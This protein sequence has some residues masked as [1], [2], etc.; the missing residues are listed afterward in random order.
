MSQTCDLKSGYLDPD[1]FYC[2]VCLWESFNIY[3]IQLSHL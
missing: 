2:S 3:E 1:R